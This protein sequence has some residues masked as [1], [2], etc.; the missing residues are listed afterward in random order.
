MQWQ[1]CFVQVDP[2]GTLGIVAMAV[3]VLRPREEQ[4]HLSL[5]QF[6]L[7]YFVAEPI[8]KL[9]KNRNLISFRPKVGPSFGTKSGP[10]FGTSSSMR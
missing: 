7:F 3:Q 4:A 2:Y 10:I 1:R 5:L 6:F 9:K 8:S